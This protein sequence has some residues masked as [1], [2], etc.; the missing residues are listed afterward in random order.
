MSTNF[1]LNNILHALKELP[2]LKKQKEQKTKVIYWEY[3]Q[4]TPIITMRIV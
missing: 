4:V 2:V 1:K 3:I